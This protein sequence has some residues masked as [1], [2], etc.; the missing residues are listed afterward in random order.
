MKA[1]TAV[2]AALAAATPL[3][4]TEEQMQFGRFG[5]VTVY[6]ASAEPGSVAL[7][8]SGDG[9]WNQGV[10]DMARTISGLDATVVGIDI[11]T[12]L[13]AL[14]ASSEA[15]VYP[16]SDFEGLSQF[17][18]K[19][20]RF[21]RY[22]APLLV[23]YS[24]GATLVYATLVEAPPGTFRGAI[25]LGFC[26]DLDLAKPLCRGHGIEAVPGPKGKGVIFQPAT[27]LEQP[28]IAFQGVIDQVCDP[29]ATQAFVGKVP[30]GEVVMLPKVGHG[31]SVPRN[32]E[33]QFK[34]AVLELTAP[35]PA[36][37]RPE[38][39]SDLPVVE[40]PAT[41]DG[42]DLAVMLS[43]DG[44]WASIDKQV[45]GVLA[46]HGVPVVGL[47]CL[48]YFWKART[49]EGLAADLTRIARYYLAAWHRSRLVLAGYSFGADVLPFAVSRL[50]ADLR[51]AVRVVAL[52]GPSPTADFEFHVGSW[53]G[54]SSP[55][56]LP[57]PPEIARLA[58]TPTLCFFGANETD[59]ACRGLDPAVATGVPMEGGHH[60]GGAYQAMADRIL[61]ALAPRPA[62]AGAQGAGSGS[63]ASSSG[64]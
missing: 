36:P 52:L 61:A 63:P 45:A 20:L 2:L 62:P 43:G 18:Q 8:V 34:A 1:A 33:P 4:A 21:S 27:T 30:H 32:W 38:A 24:S 13:K 44:G 41:G 9:G 35:E 48:Q 28:W 39:V 16:A 6:R 31:Y 29:P 12:Y 17:V 46:A 14:A 49:P 60:F 3:H 50:P 22:H 25:S 54:R 40:V 57:V 10:V 19:Q 53:L 23:G 15:C 55:S 42:Q 58:G 59:T 11:R 37:P 47:N 51:G 7:F 5:S 64:G 26:P 56:A